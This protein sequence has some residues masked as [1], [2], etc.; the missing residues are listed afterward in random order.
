M[1][2]F[3]IYWRRSFGSTRALETR[4]FDPQW[5]SFVYWVVASTIYAEVEKITQSSSNA[6]PDVK[7]FGSNFRRMFRDAILTVGNYEEMYAR[8]VEAIVP[9]SGFNLLSTE[10]EPIGPQH[11]PFRFDDGM[12]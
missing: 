2:I 6:M 9:R 11:F 4:Q 7:L 5:S 12:R 10:E 8:N 3:C 1:L